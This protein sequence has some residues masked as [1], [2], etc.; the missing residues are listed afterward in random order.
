M[1][2]AQ[3]PEDS[4]A[5]RITLMTLHSSKGQEFPYVFIVG[6]AESL[7]P[8]AN[9]MDAESIEEERRLFYVGLTRA[10]VGIAILCPLFLFQWNG[11]VPCIPSRFLRELPR[12]HDGVTLCNVRSC[13]SRRNG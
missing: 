12:E 3:L 9:A 2:D 5:E 10:Q 7:L 6:A 11:S 1:T 4:Q 8:H 13:A